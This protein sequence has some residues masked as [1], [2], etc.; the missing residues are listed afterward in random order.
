MDKPRAQNDDVSTTLLPCKRQLR[1][2]HIE[3][4]YRVVVDAPRKAKLSDP[5]Q[6]TCT[7]VSSF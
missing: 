3:Y 6:Y 5:V 2:A 7:H 1:A 4:L